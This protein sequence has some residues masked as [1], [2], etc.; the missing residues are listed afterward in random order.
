M[1]T[2]YIV[3]DQD[4][5]ITNIYACSVECN[6]PEHLTQIPVPKGENAAHY[7]PVRNSDG[8]IGLV[9][10]QAKIDNW[11]QGRFRV[12]RDQRNSLLTKCDWTQAND[13]Q[14]T[15]DQKAAWRQYRQALRDITTTTTD[16][17]SVVW[18]TP[19]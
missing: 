11:I 4:L 2:T 19:P 5:N 8:T 12:L 18:P 7:S 14:L 10:D 3:V 1:D 16:P 9:K 13:V 6:Y 17:D 15:D